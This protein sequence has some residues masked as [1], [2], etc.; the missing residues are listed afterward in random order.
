[1]QDLI[2]GAA[3]EIDMEQR[4]KWALERIAQRS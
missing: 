1:M 2:A 4:Q 3:V